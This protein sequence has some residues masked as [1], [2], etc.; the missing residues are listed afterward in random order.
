MVNEKPFFG[1]GDGGELS[2]SNVQFTEPWYL[3]ILFCIFLPMASLAY[4]PQDD[5][6]FNTRSQY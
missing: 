1:E 5:V 2:R 3:F 6:L 4:H